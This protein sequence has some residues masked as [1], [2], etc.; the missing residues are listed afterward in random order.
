MKSIYI[1]PKVEDRDAH[2]KAIITLPSQYKLVDSSADADFS[3][4][5]INAPNLA[6]AALGYY[7]EDIQKAL[8]GMTE[9]IVSFRVTRKTTYST[10]SNRNFTNLLTGVLK[11]TDA[12]EFSLK[13]VGK[14]QIASS[15]FKGGLI[16]G[17]FITSDY[18]IPSVSITVS[19][20][21]QRVEVRIPLNHNAI[22]VSIDVFNADGAIQNRA[23]FESVAK[24]FWSNASNL[25]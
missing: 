9:F 20:Q 23:K 24:S 22:P 8:G 17:F 7:K 25:A 1:D 4:T 19:S 16:S 10:E 5:P 15:S 13:D 18:A 3:V 2:A 11:L 21:E 6:V 12:Q 14:S